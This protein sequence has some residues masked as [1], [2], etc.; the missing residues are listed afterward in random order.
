MLEQEVR[1][2]QFIHDIFGDLN[3]C[4]RPVD[5]I[6]ATDIP[7][8]SMYKKTSVASKNIAKPC[9]GVGTGFF[10]FPISYYLR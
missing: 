3:P 10:Y 4:G 9:T 1:V 6:V 8:I 7:K 5:W 2:P